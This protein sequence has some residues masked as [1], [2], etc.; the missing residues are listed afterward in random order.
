VASEVVRSG[1]DDVSFAVGDRLSAEVSAMV[2]LGLPCRP[3]KGAE[4]KSGVW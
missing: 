4:G 3:D 1:A 2:G